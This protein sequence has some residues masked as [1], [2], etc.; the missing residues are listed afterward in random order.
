M[1]WTLTTSGAAIRKAGANANTTIVASG[2]ALI[3]FSDEAEAIICDICR[4]DVVTNYASLTSNGK[5]ILGGMA[6]NM[7]AQYIVNYDPAAYNA[8]EKSSILNITENQ[9]RRAE[10][11]LQDDKYKTYLGIT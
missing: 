8:S 4:S 9:I 1:S 7:I 2:A 11:M 10:K 3:S 6:S 5:A